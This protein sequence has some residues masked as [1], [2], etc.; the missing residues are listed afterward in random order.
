MKPL[1]IMNLILL[2]ALLIGG[3]S[4][5]LASTRTQNA[6]DCSAA[7]GLPQTECEALVALYTATGGENWYTQ[8]NWLTTTTPCTWYGVTCDTGHV[9][10]VSLLSNN[11][12][13]ALPPEI[14][15]LTALTRLYLWD[16]AVSALP[17]EIG[18]LSTLTWLDLESNVLSTLPPEIGNL[19]AV[20]NLFLDYN[21]LT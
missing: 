4:E 15:D 12:N 1:H 20:E 2:C 6:Y 10:Q 18:D 13:G 3:L 9:T 14:G 21:A 7:T 5:Q 11:L 8:T 16:N 19:T 17:P